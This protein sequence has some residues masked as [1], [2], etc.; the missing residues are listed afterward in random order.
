MRA[1]TF[2]DK[3]EE[4][5]LALARKKLRSDGRLETPFENREAN[6]HLPARRSR[7]IWFA[8]LDHSSRLIPLPRTPPLTAESGLL[9]RE[10]QRIRSSL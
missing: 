2:N 1:L 8:E 7:M 5:W 6:S 4:D 10:P 9:A 3:W